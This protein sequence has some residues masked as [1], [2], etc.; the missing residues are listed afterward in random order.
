VFIYRLLS[1]AV[2]IPIAIWMVYAGGL[3]FLAT[4]A[5]VAGLAG[6]EFCR[7]MRIG[8][9]KPAPLFS[10]ALVMLF[11]VDAH[12]PAWEIGPLGLTAVI[13]LSL[14]WQLFQE[15]S[16]APT[17]DWALTIVGGLYVGWMARHFIALRDGPRGLEWTVLAVLITWAGDTGAYAIGRWLA[18]LATRGLMPSV[19]GWDATSSGRA[20]APTKPGRG[21]W[22]AGCA[23]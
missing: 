2:L 15:D 1:A 5:V 8:G 14:I 22:G 7:I 18:G 16:L 20:S 3:W 4:I 11:L 17:V 6:Y 19:V 9:Y 12:Y 23:E 13:V 10:V 21:R